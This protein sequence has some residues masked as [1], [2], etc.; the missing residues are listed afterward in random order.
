[1]KKYDILIIGGGPGGYVAAIKASQLGAQV[2]LVEDHKLGGICLNYGCIPT[3][4]YLKS[5]KIFGFLKEANNFGI[6]CSGDIRFNW[7]SVL[8]RKNKIVQQLTN[9]VGFLLKKNNVDVYYG[10]AKVLTSKQVQVGDKFLETR[11]LIIA[12]GSS[13]FIPSIPGAKEAYNDN[14]LFTSKEL[15]QL[16]KFPNKI[17]IIGGGIIGVEFATIFNKFGSEV[18]ILEKQTSILNTLDQDIIAA[19]SKHL[20]K[21]NIQIVTEASVIQ[22]QDNIV[23]YIHDNKE[24]IEQ[25]DIVL[26]AVG[27]KPNLKGLEKLNLEI[28]RTG[29][30]TDNFLNTSIEGVYAVGDV[31][32][33]FMLA[34]VASHEG[35]TAVYHA[36]GKQACHKPMNYDRVPSCVYGFPEIATI[37]FTEDQAKSKGFDCKVSKFPVKA[38]GKALADGESD[39]FAKII[40]DRKNMKILGM[41]IYAYNATELITETGVVMEFEGTAH[42]VVNVIHPHPTLAELN[43]ETFLGVIDKPI[44][45]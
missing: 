10:F 36:L 25:A 41:H 34:H 17:I 42:D 27:T 43:L 11:K 16:D 28:D 37:G 30:V 3:K 1:M 13:A 23:H 14:Y 2:A 24:K 44:H 21:S 32:G 35:V 29:I 18:M 26:M 38:I 33:K 12:T 6:S 7:L 45:M 40:V 19:Y 39:G 22:I 31:N 20:E 9:G 5:A 4:A 15:V 8:Q